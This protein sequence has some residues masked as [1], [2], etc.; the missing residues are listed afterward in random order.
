MRLMQRCGAPGCPAVQAEPYCPEHTPRPAWRRGSRRWERVSRAYRA[1]HPTC[2]EAGCERPSAHVH[3]LDGLGPQGPLG[4]DWA[5]LMALCP[6]HHAKRTQ[7]WLYAQDEELR[8]SL[9]AARGARPAEPEA[10]RP[11]RATFS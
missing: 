3:H 11:G 10:R 2:E 7:P 4:F 5:N 1:K 6:S 8:L 9:Y